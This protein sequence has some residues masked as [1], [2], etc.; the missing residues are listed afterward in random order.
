[1]TKEHQHN[2]FRKHLADLRSIAPEAPEIF[3]CPI[4]LGVFP[5]ESVEAELVDTGHVW[6]S[7][8]RTRSTKAPHQQV[9]LCKP[10]NS[11]AGSAGDEFL[12]ADLEIRE[13]EKEGDLGLRKLQVTKSSR[14]REPLI[15]EAFIQ[16]RG[17]K[18]ATFFFPR[19]QNENQE[20]YFRDIRKK[21]YEYANEGPVDV[22]VFP[23]RAK[24]D[25]PFGDPRNG[26]LVQ[27]GILT[28]AYLL[29]FYA[30]GYRFILQTCLDPVRDYIQSSFNKD[31][32]DRLNFHDTKSMCV[33]VSSDHVHSEPEI[34]FVIPLDEQVPL[35]QGVQ[36]LHYHARL[37][38]PPATFVESRQDLLLRFLGVDEVPSE[39]GIPLD[40]ISLGNVFVSNLDHP[41]LATLN[42]QV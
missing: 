21:F 2:L 13:R 28:A 23:P 9:L 6:P 33:G 17:E 26:P 4:C 15:L 41:I 8:F 10:C 37:P 14:D 35:H 40:S 36:F 42:G 3:I 5:S 12:Q 7:A 38:A 32:D 39:D 11:K 24:P 18:E 29:G 30:Y 31:V 27:A 25:R 22:I 1:M 19:Y 20:R 34:G 16:Q